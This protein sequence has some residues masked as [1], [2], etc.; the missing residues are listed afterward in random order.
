MRLGPHAVP[1]R[2]L[3][4][5]RQPAPAPERGWPAALR[6][7]T[8]S[9]PHPHCCAVWARCASGETEWLQQL[10][11]PH[12]LRLPR[13][14]D[15][16]A[17]PLD[18]LLN[19]TINPTA[20]H[21]PPA[22]LRRARWWGPGW[23][24]APAPP[25][26][27]AAA[28][29]APALRQSGMP[30]GQSR[31]P[32]ASQEGDIARALAVLDWSKHV[33]CHQPIIDSREGLCQQHQGSLCTCAARCASSPMGSD[34]TGPPWL[35]PN[36]S[37]RASC[38]F[39]SGRCSCRGRAQSGHSGFRIFL[40]RGQWPG[41]LQGPGQHRPPAAS[42]PSFRTLP[43]RCCNVTVWCWCYCGSL[44]VIGGCDQ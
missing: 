10:H 21:P 20:N 3:R 23:H 25:A 35:S 26:P 8:V 39:S 42:A 2:L 5:L 29:A 27:P 32:A 24:A 41:R 36:S 19:Q 30:A 13:W 34:A 11:Q 44:Q 6:S 9:R 22:A 28:A 37:R 31:P 15:R 12:A 1:A 33:V 4:P 18:T 14:E 38:S 16:N 7:A 43:S 40:A 17:S